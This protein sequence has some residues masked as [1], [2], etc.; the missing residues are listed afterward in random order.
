MIELIVAKEAE[1]AF[2]DA[3]AIVHGEKLVGVLARAFVLIGV[4]QGAMTEFEIEM[5]RA[6]TAVMLDAIGFLFACFLPFRELILQFVF[7]EAQRTE[8]TL[9]FDFYGGLEF[10]AS[11]A[12]V[13]LIHLGK[14]AVEAQVDQPDAPIC[15]EVIILQKAFFIAFLRGDCAGEVECGQDAFCLADGAE[16]QGFLGVLFFEI[17]QA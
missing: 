8:A 15:G 11:R 2:E 17:A 1:C 14:D 12:E 7:G 13:I 9:V 4:V 3:V 10:D 5:L 16:S 6:E